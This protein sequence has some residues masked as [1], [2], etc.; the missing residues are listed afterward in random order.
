MKVTIQVRGRFYKLHA[1][2]DTGFDGAA[3][4]PGDLWEKLGSADTSS[5]WEVADSRWVEA[6]I[7]FGNIEIDGMPGAFRE[8]GITALGNEFMVGRAV[9]D[10][11]LVTLDHG[12][13]VIL[14]P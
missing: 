1:R 14:K 13:R 5:A 7:Y 11:F 2:I 10:H 9:L 6:P 3:V 8:V 4:I 12:K